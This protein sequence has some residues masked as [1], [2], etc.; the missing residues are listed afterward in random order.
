MTRLS[1]DE[2]CSHG[3]TLLFPPE[4]ADGMIVPP[5]ADYGCVNCGGAY[6]REGT[7]PMLTVLP[8]VAT[9]AVD[10]DDA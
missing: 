2:K 4:L 10:D 9:E 5:T 7:P 6:K 8:A 3:R 1:S